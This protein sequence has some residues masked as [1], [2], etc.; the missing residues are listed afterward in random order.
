MLREPQPVGR[1]RQD[2][3]KRRRRPAYKNDTKQ[4]QFGKQS[5]FLVQVPVPG[6]RHDEVG[7]GEQQEGVGAFHAVKQGCG[8]VKYSRAGPLWLRAGQE[9]GARLSPEAG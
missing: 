3:P 7:N 4:A 5:H 6:K 8:V 9:R 2:V 1:H